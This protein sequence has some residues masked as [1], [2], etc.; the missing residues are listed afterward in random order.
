MHRRAVRAFHVRSDARLLVASVIAT[1]SILRR[2]MCLLPIAGLGRMCAMVVAAC[3]CAMF[4][5]LIPAR[6]PRMIAILPPI[7]L[8]ATGRACIA[9]TIAA[10]AAI[11]LRIAVRWPLATLCGGQF[12]EGDSTVV[13]SIEP[14]QNLACSA[15][16]I[17]IERAVAICVEDS[18]DAG[19]GMLAMRRGIFLGAQRAGGEREHG[20]KCEGG[21]SFHG[22]LSEV[23]AA[24]EMPGFRC[25]TPHL[26]IFVQFSETD[27][28]SG[29]WQASTLR[30]HGVSKYA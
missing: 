3:I 4:T 29:K 12:I 2:T 5:A 18:E 28:T 14:A 9:V 10:R 26:R 11:R 27:R 13:V 20:E 1:I 22:V 15:D 16:L 25:S 23:A 7:G 19:R 24:R 6:T 30:E 21:V 17:G 8:P